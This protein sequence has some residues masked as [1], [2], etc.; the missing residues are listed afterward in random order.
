MKCRMELQTCNAFNETLA[1]FHELTDTD[2]KCS[3]RMGAKNLSPLMDK[4]WYQ[5]LVS[6]QRNMREYEDPSDSQEMIFS[7]PISNTWLWNYDQAERP[8]MGIPV[9]GFDRC[10]HDG[11]MAGRNIAAWML[12][13]MWHRVTQHKKKIPNFKPNYKVICR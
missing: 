5:P 9:G 4:H 7:N 6:Y 13:R 8:T 3:I 11:S 2:F 10:G 12:A 1:F